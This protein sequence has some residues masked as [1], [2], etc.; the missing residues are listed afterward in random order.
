MKRSH[1]LWLHR[2]V[3]LVL[4]GFLLV[5]GLTGSLLAFYRPLDEA[6]AAA[7]LKAPQ[8][9]GAVAL[10]P[11]VV[12]E[13]LLRRHA[14]LRIDAVPLSVE[15]GRSLAFRVQAAPGAAAALAIDELYVDPWTGR[16]LGGRLWGDPAQGR[17]NVMPFLYRLHY[18]LLAPSWGRTVLGLVALLWSLDCVVGAYLTLPLRMPRREGPLVRQGR[19]WW[20][21]WRQAWCV[22]R[23]AGYRSTVDLHRAGGLWLWA[24]LFVIAWSGVSFNL[25]PVYRPVMA[26]L[27]GPWEAAPLPQTAGL[28]DGVEPDWPA[29]RAHARA[30]MAAAAGAEGIAVGREESLALDRGA[31]TWRYVVHS[32]RDV[33]PQRGQSTL[34]FDAGSGALLAVQW[35]TGQQAARTATTWLTALHTGRVGGLP[36]RLL[37]AATG[38]VV[39]MLSVTGALIW[40]R[41]R[42]GR[43]CLQQTRALGRPESRAAGMDWWGEAASARRP[44]AEHRRR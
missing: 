7:L 39:A 41:K 4:A 11:L 31:G 17:V 25:A 15:P 6:F 29:A 3:G 18:A 9:V 36:L 43:R 23:G 13:R 32:D 2:W 27:L 10:D 1:W 19:G 44:A 12:R 42:A 20:A 21:R 22:R 5:A 37:L 30:L 33:G 34:L 16:E 24:L 8:P 28:A 40:A 14:G 26:A 38:L 35:P